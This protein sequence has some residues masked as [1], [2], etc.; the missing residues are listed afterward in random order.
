MH[1]TVILTRT[2][3]KITE[4]AHTILVLVGMKIIILK[5]FHPTALHHSAQSGIVYMFYRIYAYV[6]SMLESEYT[7]FFN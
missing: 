7:F 5:L 6:L 1:S 4:I 2:I 3:M